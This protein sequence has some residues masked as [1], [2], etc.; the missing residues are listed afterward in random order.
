MELRE[1]RYFIAVVKEG[2][3]LK[4]A[5]SLFITQP[6]LSRQM[7]NLEDEI[8]KP[9]FTRGTKKITLTE[10]GI[11]LYKRAEEILDLYEKTNAEL[12]FSQDD[13]SGDIYIGGGESKTIDIVASVAKSIISLYPNIKFHFYS[14]DSSII[15]DKLDHGL[16]DF[17]IFV[18]PVDLSKYEYVNLPQKDTWGVLMRKDSELSEKENITPEDLWDKPLIRSDQSM[19]KNNLFDWFKKDPTN[20][21]IVATYNLLFNASILVEEGVGYA[22]GLDNIINT[23]G[24]SKLCF[25]PLNPPLYSTLVFAWKKHQVFSKASGVFLK[26]MLEKLNNKE[27]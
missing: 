2:S 24:D 12:A 20:L 17:G 11:L 21:N 7:K 22:I 18:N 9:L 1:L 23:S 8:G 16:I 27:S 15:L 26:M 4:A 6:S 19:R 14:G 5:Q 13:I 3:I 10:T 25:K